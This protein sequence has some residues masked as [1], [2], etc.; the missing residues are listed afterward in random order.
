MNSNL[1]EYLKENL[2]DILFE[3]KGSAGT[4]TPVQELL[5]CVCFDLFF[6][7]NVKINNENDLKKVLE[8]HENTLD[9]IDSK[10]DFPFKEIA[11]NM[12]SWENKS[13][14][15]E[16][17]TAKQWLRSFYYQC[18]SFD[19]FLNE[20][21]QFPQSGIT[22]LHHDTKIG[23]NNGVVST[24]WSLLVDRVNNGV[25][26]LAGGGDKDLYQ[27]ADIYAI[28]DNTDTAIP[29]NSLPEEI[30]YW[31]QAATEDGQINDKFVGISLKKLKKPLGHVKVYNIENSDDVMDASEINLNINPW[32]G[33]KFKSK[34]DFTPGLLTGYI[35]FKLKWGKDEISKILSIKSNSLSDDHIDRKKAWDFFHANTTI[36]L[37]TKN[38]LANEGKV[39]SFINNILAELGHKKEKDPSYYDSNTLNVLISEINSLCKE[40]GVD[41]IADMTKDA[42]DIIDTLFIEKDSIE[43]LFKAWDNRSKDPQNAPERDVVLMFAKAIKWKCVV[44]KQLTVVKA[45]LMYAQKLKGDNFEKGIDLSSLA[46]LLLVLVELVK[47]AKGISDK[48]LPYVMIG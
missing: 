45:I 8:E 19:N 30:L 29:S 39:M 13:N 14:T 15:S 20:N 42:K 3:V 28:W 34:E 2:Q 23:I 22:F 26:K 31:S 47:G 38:G 6:N 1:V 43:N 25:K 10:T 35:N 11:Y 41:G 46:S 4:E 17:T 33:A 12:I 32:K 40:C 7:Q 5:T 27:K 36:E 37:S 9:E 18:I 48:C 21:K 16:K 44:F 24:G